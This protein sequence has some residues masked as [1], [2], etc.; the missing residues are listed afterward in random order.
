[1]L[2]AIINNLTRKHK[3]ISNLHK[4]GK[5]SKSEPSL[6]GPPQGILIELVKTMLVKLDRRHTHNKSTWMNIETKFLAF[7]MNRSS[8]QKKKRVAYGILTRML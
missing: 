3:K 5:I 6:A 8:S 1:M 7:P 2:G 4:K